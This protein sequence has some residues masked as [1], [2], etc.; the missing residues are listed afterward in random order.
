MSIKASSLGDGIR[1][2]TFVVAQTRLIHTVNFVCLRQVTP[3]ADISCLV[4]TLLTDMYVAT[5]PVAIVPS[6]SSY[7]EFLLLFET[8]QAWHSA[9]AV[10]T[11]CL[12]VELS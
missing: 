12:K 4:K 11:D 7:L 10:A 3:T 1:N 6:H 5:C 8:A 2:G 9:Q